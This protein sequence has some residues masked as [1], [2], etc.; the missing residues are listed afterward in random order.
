MIKA[1]SILSTVT[2]LHADYE[3]TEPLATITQT[4]TMGFEI[5]GEY[6]GEIVFGLYGEVVPKT[7]LNFATLCD[8]SSGAIDVY[9]KPLVYA[10]TIF[11][12]ILP[13]Y[14]VQAGNHNED[15]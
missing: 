11:N 6:M 2:A 15:S 3:P 8:Q 9:G 10:G 5:A 12:T 4:C 14:I 13:G 7:V 1:L